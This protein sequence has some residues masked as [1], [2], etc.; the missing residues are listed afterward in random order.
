MLIHRVYKGKYVHFCKSVSLHELR[1][2]LKACRDRKDSGQYVDYHVSS[3]NTRVLL[4][5]FFFQ[6]NSK[7][8]DPSYKMDLDLWN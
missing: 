3:D 1:G 5:F 2:Y 4:F 8:L 6:N 7:N